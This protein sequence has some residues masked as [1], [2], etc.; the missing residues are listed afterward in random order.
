MANVYNSSYTGAWHDS[1]KPILIFTSK[2]VATS[3]WASDS[4]YSLYPYK[5]DVTCAGVTTSHFPEVVFDL[6]DATSGYFAPVCQS[7]SGAVRIY[8]SAIPSTSITIGS[9]KC[10]ASS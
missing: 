10:T 8:A 6:T 5:A 7:V 2:T 4:T 3:T 9:I 1:H